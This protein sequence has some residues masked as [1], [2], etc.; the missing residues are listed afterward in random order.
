MARDTLPLTQYLL[1][2]EGDSYTLSADQTAILSG[3]VRD[4]RSWV[5]PGPYDPYELPSFLYIG[6]NTSSAGANFQFTQVAVVPEPASAAFL[7]V[8]PLF[9]RRRRDGN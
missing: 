1:W 4:Y 6:D 9:L 2:I 7:A 8:A 3:A 5:S